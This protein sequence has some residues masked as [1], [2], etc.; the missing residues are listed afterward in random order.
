[1]NIICF[2][3]T[4]EYLI[5][6]AP[7]GFITFVSK[8]FGGRTSDGII[9]NSS[10][11]LN[12]M[13]PG[14]EIM[15][16]TVFP[17]IKSELL[18]RQSLLIM[19]PFAFNPQFTRKEVLERYSIAAVRIHVERA[20]QRLKTFRTLEHIPHELFPYIDKVMRVVAVLA[21]NKPAL[22]ERKLLLL[23]LLSYM[24]TQISL[25]VINK[26]LKKKPFD[27]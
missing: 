5:A 8:G 17:Q 13:E 3:P 24:Y 7:L 9:T 15:A 19:P 21:N 23:Q 27:F 4:I 14:D 25:K 18:K 1:M 6:V 12:L 11:F 10:G 26:V 22:I 2:L 16:D 20:I